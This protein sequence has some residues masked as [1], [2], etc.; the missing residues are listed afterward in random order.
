MLEN[1]KL[2]ARRR[3]FTI[4]GGTALAGIA[5]K[6]LISSASAQTTTPGNSPTITPG[7]R[8]TNTPGNTPT[9]APRST[10]ATPAVKGDAIDIL[11]EDHRRIEALL[12]QISQTSANNP[13]QRTQLLQ[14]LISLL[15]IHNATEEHLVYPAIYAIAN[16]QTN[17]RQLYQQQDQAK[18]L[19]F[20]LDQLSKSDPNWDDRFNVFRKAL[21]AHVSQEEKSDF[22]RLR[23]AAGNKLTAITAKVRQLRSQFN[24]GQISSV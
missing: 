22:P 19:T 7:S 18:L 17:A 13:T 20:E 6:G 15:T 1:L 16:L 2:V 12:N 11:L 14:Q 21:L 9:T 5:A 24:P 3:F 8:P 4:F 23:Q 10:P